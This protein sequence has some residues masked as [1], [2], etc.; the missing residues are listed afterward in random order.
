MKT[1]KNL[2]QACYD[3]IFSRR[4][5][6]E[7]EKT[8]FR[9]KEM[10]RLENQTIIEAKLFASGFGSEEKVNKLKISLSKISL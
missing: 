9:L 6:E 8:N 7:I 4:N 2:K 10:R 1:Y 5:Q 3:K